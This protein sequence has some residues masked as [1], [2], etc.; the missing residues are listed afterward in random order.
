MH[1]EKEDIRQLQGL[2][3]YEGVRDS[4]ISS[5]DSSDGMHSAIPENKSTESSVSNK[6]PHNSGK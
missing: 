5:I 2:A 3:L 1:H 4:L 6:L